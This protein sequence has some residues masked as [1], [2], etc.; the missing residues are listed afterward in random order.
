MA[1]GSSIHLRKQRR[2]LCERQKWKCYWCQGVMRWVVLDGTGTLPLDAATLDHLDDRWSDQRG[3]FSGQ[4]RRVAACRK[5]NE[6]RSAERLKT[7]YAEEQKR[8]SEAGH[9]AKRTKEDVRWIARHN[10]PQ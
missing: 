3:Q 10:E 8:R 9:E 2:E 6:G 1:G 7:I 5:C 4:R